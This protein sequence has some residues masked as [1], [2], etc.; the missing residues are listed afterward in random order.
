MTESILKIV[1][2][3]YS[4]E[5]GKCAIQNINLEIKKGEKIAV[6]GNNG[7]GKSTFF[8]TLN[9][10]IK[11]NKGEIY[12]HGEKLTYS[13][14]NLLELR[15]SIGMVFQNPDD[16]I[17]ASTVEGEISF[18]LFNIGMK[19]DDVEKKVTQ[20]MEELNLTKY[21]KKPPHFLSGGEK[22]RI[23][24]ADILVMEPELIL[25]DEPTANLDYKN[26]RLF[27]GQLEE[28]NKKGVTLLISTHDMN[29][30]WEWAERVVVFADGEIIAD[31]V[32]EKIFADD[33]LIER[34]CIQ[35]PLLF[36]TGADSSK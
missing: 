31:D 36:S 20:I 28:L 18:G 22:K 14:K 29:F 30:V 5:E 21:R 7:A 8:L 34:A 1:D 4:Y 16:Q 19:R 15:K 26:I 10:V 27:H 3:T 23:T 2:A 9:A 32:P 33:N 17:I 6:I 13:R 25:F 11:L 24:I 12:F 35:K